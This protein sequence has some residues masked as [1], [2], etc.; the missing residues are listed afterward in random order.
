MLNK[1]LRKLIPRKIQTLIKFYKIFNKEYGHSNFKNNFICDGKDN[2]LPWITYPCIEFL[3]RINLSD[4][5][6]FEFGAGSSTHYWAKKSKTVTSIEKDKNWYKSLESRVPKNAQ[7]T[8]SENDRHYVDHIKTSDKQYD[9]IVV[10]GAVRY[11]CA[12]AAIN[13]ISNRGIILLD[14]TEWYP[15]TAKLLTSEGFTQIDFCGFPPINAFTSCTSIFFKAG[16]VLE[17]RIYKPKWRPMGARFL[18]AYDDKEFSQI[19]EK[20]L[21]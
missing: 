7:I 6:V 4:C 16:S 9:V 20:F 5:D 3:D 8:L 1:I 12:K 14:N 21:N 11:P 17:N 2:P 10:D 18:N 19:E 15:E 13:C